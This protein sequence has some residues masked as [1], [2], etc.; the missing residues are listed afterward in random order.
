[1]PP[2]GNGCMT[3]TMA[4]KLLSRTTA[5]FPVGHSAPSTFR[6]CGTI[7]FFRDMTPFSS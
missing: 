3:V 1:M 4:V 7:C 6:R 5:G 2:N